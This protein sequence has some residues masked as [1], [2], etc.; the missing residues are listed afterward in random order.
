MT[1]R[2]APVDLPGHAGEPRAPVRRVRACPVLHNP[3]R[4]L[5]FQH[6]YTGRVGRRQP[7][8]LVAGAAGGARA[9]GRTGGRTGGGHRVRRRRHTVAAGRGAVGHVARHGARALHAGAG[10]RD[11]HRGQ[12]RVDVAGILCS[13]PRGRLHAGV[14]GHAVGGTAGAGG[15][16]PD[17]LTEPVGGRGPRGAGCRLRTR[18]PRPDL[19]HAG[20]VRR[21]PVVVGRDGDRDGRRPRVGLCPGRRGGHRVGPAGP[22]R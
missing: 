7:R 4:L 5:R 22:Q 13:D 1:L 16:R 10:R 9:G 19:R 21:R 18:Q 17:T 8:R 14:A 20:G 2:Q 15:S 12:P 6:L 11:H 3:L